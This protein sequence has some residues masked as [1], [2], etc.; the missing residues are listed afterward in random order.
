MKEEMEINQ[1]EMKEELETALSNTEA[2]LKQLEKEKVQLNI[3]LNTQKE[4]HA[5]TLNAEKTAMEAQLENELRKME[6]KH[7]KVK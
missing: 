2:A 6:E 7:Q 4:E 3:Q 5:K 1:Q